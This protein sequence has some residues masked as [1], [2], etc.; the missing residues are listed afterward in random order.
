MYVNIKC[1]VSYLQEKSDFFVSHKG[2]RQG[3]NLSPLLL[4]LYVNDLEEYSKN[5]NCACLKFDDDWL[6]V[7]LKGLV[8]ICSYS[9]PSK[10][11][12]HLW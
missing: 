3:G 2:V 6:D 9:F 1:C 12:G 5:N 11:A 10:K 8:L 7:Y 4:A